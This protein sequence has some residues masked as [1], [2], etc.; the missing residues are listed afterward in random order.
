MSGLDQN[1]GQS[2][3]STHPRARLPRYFL[4]DGPII[5]TDF[6]IL[7]RIMVAALAEEIALLV[8]IQAWVGGV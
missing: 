7:V 6:I 5:Q 8:R 3:R 4:R 1:H 2:S